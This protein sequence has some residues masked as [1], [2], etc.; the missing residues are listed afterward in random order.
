MIN[1][2]NLSSLLKEYLK[3]NTCKSIFISNLNGEILSKEGLS[4][5]VMTDIV[6]TIWTEYNEIGSSILFNSKLK[7][8]I[9]ETE[10]LNIL[11]SPLYGYIIVLISDKSIGLS[12]MKTGLDSIS[13]IL[14]ERFSLFANIISDEQEEN[15]VENI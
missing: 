8:M 9:I 1:T 2:Q 7:T 3:L 13:R 5:T 6:S 14:Q 4:N 15:V 10:T 12:V 11:S